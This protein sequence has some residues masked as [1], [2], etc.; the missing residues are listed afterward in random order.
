VSFKIPQVYGFI[1]KLRRQSAELIKIH[2]SENIRIIGHGETRY[3]KYN[4]LKLGGGQ[5]YYRSN[6]YLP[7]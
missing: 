1:T 2:D 6:V 3:R 7:L 4:R 5:A